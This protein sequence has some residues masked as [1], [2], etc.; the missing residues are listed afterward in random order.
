MVFQRSFK[1]I[2][3]FGELP[4]RTIHGAS[5][6]NLINVEILKSNFSLDYVEEYSD[7]K[8]HKSFSFSKTIFFLGSLSKSWKLYSQFKYEFFYG[9]IYLSFGGILKNLLL[10]VVFKIFNPSSEIILHFHRSDIK[11]FLKCWYCNILFKILD[12]F[13]SKYIVLSNSQFE[14]ISSLTTNKVFLLYNSIQE[15][16]FEFYSRPRNKTNKIRVIF[17]SNFLKEKGFFDL[18]KV[19]SI[20][21]ARYP[22]C[23]LLDCYGEFGDIKN[24]YSLISKFQSKNIF[25][26]NSIYGPEKN[27]VLNSCDIIVL[28]SYNEGMPL[29][30]LEALYLGKPIIISKV[31]YINEALGEEYPLY[32]MAGDIDSIVKCFVDFKYNYSISDL[33]LNLKNMYSKFS[34]EQHKETLFKI[35]NK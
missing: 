7:L 25:I 35:F 18:L 1:K 5:I 4:P 15:N 12:K 23:F 17:F 27:N 28:P 29:I 26:H 11:F 8:H 33:G 21:E 14:E 9:V 3:F 20:L 30:L 2:F 6:S 24:Q 32:C 13:V 31:G 16:E 10:T 34:L 22:G 19:F